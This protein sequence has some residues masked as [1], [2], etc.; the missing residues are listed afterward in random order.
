MQDYLS[1]NSKEDKFD[2]TSLIDEMPQWSAPFGLDILE[3]VKI[4]P[5]ITALDV[6]S[7]LGFPLIELATRLGESGKVIGIIPWEKAVIRTNYLIRVLHINNA[8]V[9]KGISERM[10]FEDNSFS[11]IVS[12]NCLASVM[13]IEKSLA[14]YHRVSKAEAQFVFT[15]ILSDTMKEFYNVVENT[16]VANDLYSEIDQIKTQNNTHRKP[17]RDVEST[18]KVSGFKIRSIKMNKLNIGFLDGESLLNHYMVKYWL[19]DEWKK[20]IN[21]EDFEVIFKQVASQINDIAKTKGEFLLS[22]HYAT[23]DSILC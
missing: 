18:L 22:I 23:I 12:N 20:V 8:T 1:H 3:L 4:K 7:R 6:G 5:D 19:L 13:N 14:E 15:V 11:L 21:S 9:I 2:L 10:P 16:L 17:L